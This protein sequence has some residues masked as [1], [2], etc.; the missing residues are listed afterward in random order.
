MK[1]F[2]IINSLSSGGAERVTVTLA[3][4]F[5]DKGYEVGLVT[6]HT[7]E[8]DFY[9]LDS[10]VVRFP[11]GLGGSN[12]GYRKLYATYRRWK[13]LRHVLRNEQPDV[14]VA[15][16]TTSIILA[17]VASLKLNIR[18][19]GSERNF[20]GDKPISLPWAL[21]RR[22]TY[23]FAH[24]HIAQ[25]YETANWL[26]NNTGADNLD[27]I[28]NPVAWPIAKFNPEIKPNNIL[29]PG[30]K[31][32]LAV[33]SKPDQKGFDLLVLAFSGLASDWPEWDLVILGVDPES[34]AICGGGASVK[35]VVNEYN[36]SDR[37]FLPGRAGNVSDWYDRAD[38]FVLSSRYEGFPNVLLEAMASGN[39]S[40]AVDCN[41]GPRDIIQDG[42]NGLLVPLD[43]LQ[44]GMVRLIAD[45]TLRI[46]LGEKATYVKKDF[47]EKRV[48]ELWL[49][50]LR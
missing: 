16:M 38:I 25:T 46:K 15:M 28:P 10:R 47:S 34:E 29:K 9:P 22:I 48:A 11:L 27:V 45:D 50:I 1:V 18:V 21:L 17:I 30:R 49:E 20:P 6:M 3:N 31:V 35:R 43:S 12:W 4:Y 36:I 5:V 2:F 23:R 7:E 8:R 33:G 41:T 32:I 42:V 44:A 24:G 26:R 39:A 40:V 13:V 37:V 14:V 19:F